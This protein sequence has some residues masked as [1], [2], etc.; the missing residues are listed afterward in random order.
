M[1]SN[2]DEEIKNFRDR[3]QICCVLSISKIEYYLPTR[4]PVSQP[5][6]TNRRRYTAAAQFTYWSSNPAK[7]YSLQ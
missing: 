5:L 7:F 4:K 2:G 1:I 3:K 6:V